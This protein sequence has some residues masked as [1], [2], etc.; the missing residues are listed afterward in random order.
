MIQDFRNRIN[1][2][3]PHQLTFHLTCDAQREQMEKIRS[4]CTNL[5]KDVEHKFQEY[6]DKVGDKVGAD[7]Y[8]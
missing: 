1:S 5:S 2:L 7:P 3:F 4:S 6:L 8:F